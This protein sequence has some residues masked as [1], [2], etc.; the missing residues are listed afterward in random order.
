[1]NVAFQ[2]QGNAYGGGSLEMKVEYADGHMTTYDETP[3]YPESMLVWFR[4][5]YFY[6]KHWSCS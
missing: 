2:V 6:L 5:I 3:L 1:M 4:F